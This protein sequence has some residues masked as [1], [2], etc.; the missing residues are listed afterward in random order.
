MKHLKH[1]LAINLINNNTQREQ[2]F[3]IDDLAS[4]VRAIEQL[5][6]NEQTVIYDELCL[7]LRQR[8]FSLFRHAP[9]VAGQNVFNINI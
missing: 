8:K 3:D 7:G 1:R 2:Q 6:L 4:L 5:L 9:G